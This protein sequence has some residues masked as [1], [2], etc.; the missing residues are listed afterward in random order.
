MV[1]TTHGMTSSI[2]VGMIAICLTTNNG[3]TM[4]YQIPDAI[5]DPNSPFNILGIL[6]LGEFFG[7][8]DEPPT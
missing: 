7:R 2:Y 5:Y 6:F 8:N 3:K 1:K 4:Q